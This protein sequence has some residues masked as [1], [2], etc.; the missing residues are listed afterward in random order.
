VPHDQH[1][2]EPRSQFDD[3]TPGLVA[4]PFGEFIPPGQF[5][6]GGGTPGVGPGPGNLPPGI[7]G[8]IPPGIGGSNPG[9]GKIK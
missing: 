6:L 3:L 1:A 8:A 2:S 5:Q 9:K 7:T 4:F